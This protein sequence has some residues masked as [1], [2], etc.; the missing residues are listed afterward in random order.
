[1]FFDFGCLRIWGFQKSPINSHNIFKNK[2]LLGSYDAQINILSR[3]QGSPQIKR[4]LVSVRQVFPFSNPE[5]SFSQDFE[6]RRSPHLFS[7]FLKYVVDY[8]CYSIPNLIKK[9]NR[10]Y[11]EETAIWNF[12]LRDER[13]Q[14]CLG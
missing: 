6:K 12:F 7:L 5:L 10:N 2:I 3:I 13:L 9:K 11:K 8:Q 4:Q 14:S 1:M